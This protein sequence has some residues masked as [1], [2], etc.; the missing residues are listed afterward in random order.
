MN[1]L[2]LTLIWDDKH[3]LIN[4][5]IK[6]YVQKKKNESSKH[7]TASVQIYQDKL[8]ELLHFIWTFL[9]IFRN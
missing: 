9:L 2:W 7:V 6:I 5:S 1:H 4:P 8:L 3:V